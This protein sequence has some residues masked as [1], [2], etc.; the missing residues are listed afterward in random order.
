MHVKKYVALNVRWTSVGTG[1]SGPCSVTRHGWYCLLCCGIAMGSV[2]LCT[3]GVAGTAEA[4]IQHVRDTLQQKTP[5]GLCD[6]C[7]VHQLRV[8]GSKQQIL[9]HLLSVC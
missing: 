5:S 8:N 9:D 2:D 4:A 6:I 1:W 7:A 3:S